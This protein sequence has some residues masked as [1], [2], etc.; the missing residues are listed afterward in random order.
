MSPHHADQSARI[1]S[2]VRL[3]R[4]RR[5]AL[6]A[7]LIGLALSAGVMA[8]VSVTAS[9]AGAPDG[10]TG[11]EHARVG[12]EPGKIKH[13]WL[14]ILENKSYDA[15]FTGLNNNTYLWQTLPSQ[16]V[17]LKNYYGT[18]HFSLDNYISMVSG[19]ATQPDTQADCPFYDKF[20]GTVDTSGTLTTNPNYGQ[21]VS[22]AGAERR[23]RRQRLRLPDERADAVQPARRRRCQLE[24]LRPG[25]RQPP[26]PAGPTHSQ[27]AQYC[28]APYATPG[29]TGN[30]TQPEP[31]RRERDRPVRAQALPVPVVRLD[32]AVRR[33]QLGAHRQPV[34]PDQRPLPRPAERGD[35]AGVQLDLAEQ[36]Q[37]RPRRRLPRQQPVGRLL[38]PEHAERAASTTPAGC[39]RR[40][41]SS[42]TS[43]RR[44]RPR[45]RS[46]TAA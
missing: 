21:I 29:A 26:T 9:S 13:V 10:P 28:G 23:G 30:T 35:D 27:G 24:G 32:A 1:G 14:I 33:L 43:S 46:R 36:L 37:R 6:I 12:I 25:P 17:L 16:G 3:R 42:S 20:S 39:T 4:P 15:T 45:R 44:S 7:G 31:G 8:T 38:G 41:C 5:A 11:A 34:R 40:T 22:A 18:G 19:Q 2:R